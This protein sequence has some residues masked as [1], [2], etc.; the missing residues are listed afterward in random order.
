MWI[1]IVEAYNKTIDVVFRVLDWKKGSPRRE[2]EDRRKE[3][4]ELSCAAQIK[5]DINEMQRIRAQIAKVDRDIKSLD[6]K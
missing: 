4:E 5:G 3:L 1:A 2:L 6:D